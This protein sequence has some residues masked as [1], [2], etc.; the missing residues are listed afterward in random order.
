[1]PCRVRI[2]KGLRSTERFA[3]LRAQQVRPNATG[4]LALSTRVAT[5]SAERL[6]HAPSCKLATRTG[7]NSTPC[8]A[9][10]GPPP[11]CWSA[12]W[13]GPA[14][15][16]PRQ[17]TARD[18]KRTA[19]G[20]RLLVGK[21][22]LKAWGIKSASAAPSDCRPSANSTDHASSRRRT[23]EPSAQEVV[24]MYAGPKARPPRPTPCPTAPTLRESVGST[25][26]TAVSRR[27]R[28][29]QLRRRESSGTRKV[30]ASGSAPG[31]GVCRRASNSRVESSRK[32]WRERV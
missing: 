28:R 32:R 20:P 19:E 15:E 24:A 17:R 18:P 21:Q 27:R 11:C 16:T 10:A 14:S 6:A 31:P 26:W 29:R 8:L 2:C 22:A 3:S 12:M 1:M 7:D 23:L 4:A 13:R 9:M 5:R 25:R 30:S